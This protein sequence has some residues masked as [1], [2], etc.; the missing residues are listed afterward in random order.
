MLAQAA[1]RLGFSTAVWA[2]D[3]LA[4]A[5][6]VCA[7]RFEAAYSDEAALTDFAQACD[8][9][10]FEFENVPAATLDKL[11][12]QVAVRP[13]PH[14]LAT[15]Q[16]RLQEKDFLSVLD[17]PVPDY[18][19]V[20][21][22]EDLAEAM[23]ILAG[24]C[25]LKARR[26]GYDGKGQARLGSLSEAKAVWAQIGGVPA[27][28]ERI[29]PFDREISI[30]IARTPGGTCSAYLPPENEHADG[31]LRRS[32]VPARISE[33]VLETALSYAQSIV[34]AMDYVGLLAVEMFVIDSGDRV[35]VNEMAPR[36]HNSGHWTMEGAVTSQF[37]QHVRAIAG[38][39]LGSVDPLGRAEMRNLIG[40]EIDRWCD[41]LE[42][43]AAHVHHYGKVGA[44]PGRK[45]G[46]VTWV[47]TPPK[48]SR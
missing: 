30:L 42:D 5:F 37:E 35:L 48:K 44:R 17:I 27:I 34:E 7:R 18:R 1:A 33:Q 41:L 15:T 11:A 43:P 8:V 40:A 24:P 10:T 3:A 20:D 47:E 9:V 32:F 2:P 12:S 36:V 39:P 19:A 46:H 28:V 21:S 22:A 6:Q 25:L 16:D 13:S 45:M 4:P 29:V 31:I 23:Q 14:A 38:L 26:F